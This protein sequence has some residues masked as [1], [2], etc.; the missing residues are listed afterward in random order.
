[1]ADYRTEQDL[2]FQQIDDATLL[3]EIRDLNLSEKQAATAW[4]HAKKS[5]KFKSLNEFLV[6]VVRAQKTLKDEK[7]EG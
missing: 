2:I 5:G 6:F 7:T 3:Q 1:M 4:R